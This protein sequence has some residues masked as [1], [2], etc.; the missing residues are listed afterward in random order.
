MFT[1]EEEIK[2]IC[3]QCGSCVTSEI[4]TYVSAAEEPPSTQKILDTSL[5]RMKCSR[6]G[7][8]EYNTGP[9][10]YADENRKNFFAMGENVDAA[11]MLENHISLGYTVRCV[12]EIVDLCEKIL[13]DQDDLDDRVVEM[14]KVMNAVI[15]K[16]QA[17]DQM[18]YAPDEDTVY[19]EL[20]RDAA[21]LGRIPF[22]Q[23]MYDD[24][25]ERFQE[26]LKNEDDETEINA[27]WAMHFFAEHYRPAE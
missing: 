8:T 15:L 17:Y 21:S 10:F 23:A 26:D 27:E 2:W 14:M 5:F 9:L 12:P 3:P 16:G 25:S 6:C 18:L 1:R 13:I 11:E 24:L 22:L 20:I 7:R 4:Y 19:F